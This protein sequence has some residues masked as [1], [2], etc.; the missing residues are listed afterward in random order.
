MFQSQQESQIDN[1][2]EENYDSER[3][4]ETLPL[5]SEYQMQSSCDYVE[6]CLNFKSTFFVKNT[7]KEHPPVPSQ[8]Q[9]QSQNSEGQ[10]SSQRTDEGR[11]KSFDDYN[12]NNTTSFLK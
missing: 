5:N 6:P 4:N 1:K 9:V 3:Q 2:G 10:I 8:L 11:I 12:N 7:S